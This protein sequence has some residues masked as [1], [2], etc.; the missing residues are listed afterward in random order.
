[1][2]VCVRVFFSTPHIRHF[3]TRSPVGKCLKSA[4]IAVTFYWVFLL[5]F[6]I[7]ECSCRKHFPLENSAQ[8]RW[9]NEKRRQ[10]STVKRQHGEAQ[11]LRLSEDTQLHVS[12]GNSNKGSGK[13]VT[14]RTHDNK[15]SNSYDGDGYG[16]GNTMTEMTAAMGQWANCYTNRKYSFFNT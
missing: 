5:I 16:D 15:T 4:T 10:K 2:V 11:R 1:M 9:R 7:H 6:C 8:R 3:G 12:I 13:V 14:W